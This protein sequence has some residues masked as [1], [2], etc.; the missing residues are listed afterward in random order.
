MSLT[1]IQLVALWGIARAIQVQFPFH[2]I[3]KHHVCNGFGRYYF[4]LIFQSLY[5]FL[6]YLRSFVLSHSRREEG[7]WFLNVKG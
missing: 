6:F 2:F 4:N 5:Y 3:F 7:T 1:I